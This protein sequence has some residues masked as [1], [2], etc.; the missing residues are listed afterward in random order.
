[1]LPFE[2]RYT[3]QRQ[4]REVGHSGQHRIEASVKQLG[5]SAADDVAA[6]YLARAGVQVVRRDGLPGAENAQAR[7]LCTFDGPRDYLTG[8][9][10]ALDHL[11]A[12]LASADLAAA[13]LAA[14]DE[15]PSK[16]PHDE[17][18]HS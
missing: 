17:T 7:A 1:M 18:S 6:D 12:V 9:L 13:D 14:A 2:D 10:A 4:L 8:A 15:A 3:R 16:K 5:R 11:R